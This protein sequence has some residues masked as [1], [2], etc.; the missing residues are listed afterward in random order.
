MY[1]SHCQRLFDVSI[2]WLLTEH[3]EA[4]AQ[5]MADLEPGMKM[6]L[7]VPSLVIAV[8]DGAFCDDKINRITDFVEFICWREQK[9][10]SENARSENIR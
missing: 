4:T 6:V 7:S 8:A 10:Q 5:I 9:R 1:W 2:D 3:G